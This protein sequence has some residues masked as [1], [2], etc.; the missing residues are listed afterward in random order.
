[1]IKFIKNFYKRIFP[2]VYFYLI[3]ELKDCESVLD[4]GCGN[5]S[6]LKF[7]NCKYKVGVDI[8]KPYIE[9]SKK[10]KIH[11]KYIKKD[12]R[13]VDFKKKSF[14]AVVAWDVIEHLSKEE[15]INLIKKMEKW[16]KKKIIIYTPNGFLNQKFFDKNK[17]QEHK[18]G[19]SVN[20]FRKLGFIVYGMHGIKF[21]RGERASIKLKPIKF[22]LFI[23]NISQKITYHFP[24]IAFQLLAVK[25]I[26]EN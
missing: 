12:I 18:S 11:H 5:N 25:N 22:W 26:D 20:D 2:E 6:P 9:E 17:F 16:A 7:V 13:K 15:G 19:W 14:D 8:F 23:S 10:R 24:C 3:K 4:L 21:L 1:M